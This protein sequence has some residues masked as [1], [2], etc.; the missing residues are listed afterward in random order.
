MV[1][2][3][4]TV[5]LLCRESK[6]VCRAVALPR[7]RPGECVSVTA[8]DLPTLLCHT[9]AHG[10]QAAPHVR[11]ATGMVGDDAEGLTDLE[12]RHRRATEEAVL[13]VGGP[14]LDAVDGP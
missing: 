13:L 7:P 1:M 2:I 11:G 12:A 10:I 6:W 9:V 14:E 3:F 5:E 8:A 4:M